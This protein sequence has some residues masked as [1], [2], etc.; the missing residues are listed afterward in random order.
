MTQLKEDLAKI[1]E[2]DHGVKGFKN[3]LLGGVEERLGW[4]ED[5]LLYGPSSSVDP[6]SY[7]GMTYYDMSRSWTSCI[8]KE[9]NRKKAASF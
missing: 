9:G 1:S 6:R 3:K 7:F 2:D 4:F 5:D 8:V